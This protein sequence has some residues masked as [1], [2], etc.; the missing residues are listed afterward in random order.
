MKLWV[1]GA[2]SAVEEA[3][4]YEALGVNLEDPACAASREGGMILQEGERRADR[5]F[6]RGDDGCAEP[7]STETLLGGLN[8]SPKPATTLSL[9]GE[10]PRPIAAPSRGSVP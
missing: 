6:V 8:V 7:H 1:R 5:A 4:G 3:R 10:K 9:L 2:R